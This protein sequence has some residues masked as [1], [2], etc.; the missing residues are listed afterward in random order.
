MRGIKLL[1]KKLLSEKLLDK[2][3]ATTNSS[4]ESTEKKF[5]TSQ[6]ARSAITGMAAAKIGAALAVQ[7]TTCLIH[8]DKLTDQQ[9]L[10]NEKKIGKLLFSA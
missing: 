8:K 7:K 10:K 4:F 1:R 5:A 6:L 9:Q 3:S 2:N